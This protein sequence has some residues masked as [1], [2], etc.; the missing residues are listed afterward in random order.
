MTNIKPFEVEV[1]SGMDPD[2]R[3]QYIMHVSY[4]QTLGHLRA[5]IA[6]ELGLQI[7]QFTLVMKNSPVDPDVDDDI[8]FKDMHNAP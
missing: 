5:K 8:Y 4:F 7:G 2:N 1:M 6:R 3:L